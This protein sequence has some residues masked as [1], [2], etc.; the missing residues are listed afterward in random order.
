MEHQKA[1][2]LFYA[3]IIISLTAI[4][5]FIVTPFVVATTAPANLTTTS[6][7]NADDQI[8]KLNLTSQIKE[9]ITTDAGSIFVDLRPEAVKIGL[10]DAQLYGSVKQEQLVDQT[11]RMYITWHSI[12]IPAAQ[13]ENLIDTLDSPLRSQVRTEADKIEPGEIITAQ[14]DLD[15]LIAKF[16]ELKERAKGETP[17][18]LVE[19]EDEDEDEEKNGLVPSGDTGSS[20]SAGGDYGDTLSSASDFSTDLITTSWE[21]C[22]PR[23]DEAAGQVCRQAKQVET[24]EAGETV[25]TGAC[26]D[27]GGCVEIQK[28]YGEPCTVIYD[29]ENKKAYE[30]YQKFAVVDGET[31]T[32]K[33][34]SNDF[35]RSYDIYPK[36]DGCGIRHDFVGGRS[37]VQEKLYFMDNAGTETQITDCIDGEKAYAHYLTEAT[38]SPYM[39]KVNGTVTLY[40]RTAYKL[41]DGT[42]EYASEC[43][44]IDGGTREL[45]EAVC[46]Q[47]YE[48]DFTAGQ[49][50]LRTRDYYINDSNEPVYLTECSRSTTISFPHQY[51]SNGCGVINDDENLESIVQTSI[52]IDTPDDGQLEI[53]PCGDNGV[54]VP[55]TYIGV[56][57]R[58]AEFTSSGSWTA[59]VGVTEVTVFAVAGGNPGGNPGYDGY[60]LGQDGGG[61][62]GGKGG[63]SLCGTCWF[64]AQAGGGG[65]AGEQVTT[66]VSVNPGDSVSVTIGGSGQN[67]T[68]G[69]LVT[70]RSGQGL[71][72]GAAAGTNAWDCSAQTG[73]AGISCPGHGGNGYGTVKLAGDTVCASHWNSTTYNH[74]TVVGTLRGLG[75]L[76]YGAGGAGGTGGVGWYTAAGQGAPGYLKVT[77]SVN[78]YKRADDTIYIQ[79]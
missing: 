64:E 79:E 22:S 25:G 71:T 9:K 11:T 31:I 69:S 12:G 77:Y 44:A 67:T 72:Y 6:S 75:G 20:T 62:N 63:G 36:T 47:K 51:N 3:L 40:A 50:Y 7:E 49:S 18:Q 16:L 58:T 39:D 60:T 1:K 76:G 13:G 66:M 37:I 74:P 57:N 34:C 35:S 43:R 28:E 29:Y 15:S 19:K 55:Y 24:N 42:I 65:G 8:I 23:V 30:Q 59:P 21:D 45:L 17:K 61:I 4:F 2:R 26:E 70:A 5:S 48:H 33:T 41:D 27:H 78:K 73:A 46:E 14:G 54:A 32:V 10:P 38:C 68:F 52:Y 53:K 56:E